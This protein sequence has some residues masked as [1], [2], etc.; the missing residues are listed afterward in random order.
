MTYQ[1]PPPYLGAWSVPYL[2]STKMES[3]PGVASPALSELPN[4][5]SLALRYAASR[6]SRDSLSDVSINYKTEYMLTYFSF[7]D[8]P[9]SFPSLP[10]SEVAFDGLPP[11]FSSP[12]RRMIF[13]AGIG[14]G[15]VFP[16][17]GG[18]EILVNVSGNL[19]N[20]VLKIRT[21]PVSLSYVCVIW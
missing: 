7:A 15:G 11:V 12:P 6:S 4:M 13:M 3:L 16:E 19:Q 18:L 10:A 1:F 21:D 2:C 5:R 20:G 9:L 14:G 17:V 8:M